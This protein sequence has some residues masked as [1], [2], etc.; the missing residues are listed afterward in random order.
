MESRQFLCKRRFEI[1]EALQ[2]FWIGRKSFRRRMSLLM[3]AEIHVL[4][5]AEVPEIDGCDVVAKL[6]RSDRFIDSQSRGSGGVVVL[7]RSGS[8]FLSIC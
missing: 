8:L 3:L 2:R 4:P 5:D 1:A 6:P 7:V